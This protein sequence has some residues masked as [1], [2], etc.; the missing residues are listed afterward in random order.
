MFVNNVYTGTRINMYT[1]SDVIDFNMGVEILF[2]TGIINFVNNFSSGWD[3]GNRGYN[4]FVSI[5]SLFIN[6]INIFIRT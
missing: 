3:G 5:M 2:A 4:N 1:N 6:C